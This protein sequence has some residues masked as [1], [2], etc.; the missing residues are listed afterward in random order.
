VQT[1]APDPWDQVACH[2]LH[3]DRTMR[4][5][6]QT[7]VGHHGDGE[8]VRS[9]PSLRRAESREC[10][11]CR[12]GVPYI[13]RHLRGYTQP[14]RALLEPRNAAYGGS[15]VSPAPADLGIWTS[16]NI[17]KALNGEKGQKSGDMRYRRRHYLHRKLGIMSSG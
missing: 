15:V 3:H 5:G 17:L 13:D 14:V 16:A 2:P 7:N 4:I 11:T 12:P 10:G 9:A 6:K 8:S 1:L